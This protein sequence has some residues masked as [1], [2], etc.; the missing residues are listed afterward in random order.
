MSKQVIGE[1]KASPARWNSCTSHTRSAGGVTRTYSYMSECVCTCAIVMVK[2][3]EMSTLG[4][5]CSANEAMMWALSASTT[6]R[7]IRW[8]P[9][10]SSQTP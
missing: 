6:A 5:K 2:R 7:R 8:R 10:A 1:E 4:A 9:G 3:Y